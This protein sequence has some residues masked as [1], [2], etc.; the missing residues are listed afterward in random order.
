VRK[1]PPKKPN[2]KYEEPWLYEEEYYLEKHDPSAK[3]KKDDLDKHPEPWLYNKPDYQDQFDQFDKDD[4]AD[5][6]YE[7]IHGK[8]KPPSRKKKKAAEEENPYREDEIET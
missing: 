6:D 4:D 8:G 2:P 5:S 7:A 1:K 3:P